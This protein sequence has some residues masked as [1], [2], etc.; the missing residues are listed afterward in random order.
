[1]M[2][3]TAYLSLGIIFHKRIGRVV[4]PFFKPITMCIMKDIS[5]VNMYMKYI[6][7]LNDSIVN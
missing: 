7:I 3:Q 2:P 1:M 5:G 4:L 6:I